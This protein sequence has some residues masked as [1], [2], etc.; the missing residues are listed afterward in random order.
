M[1]HVGTVRIDDAFRIAGRAGRVAHAA[2]GVFLE[3]RPGEIAI[4][5]GD[6]VLI[7][8]RVAQARLWHVR[9][10]GQDDVALDG[11]EL[12]LQLL[13]E[14]HESRV[15]KHQPV[16]GVIGD[17]GDL[18]G[19]EAWI[20]GVIDRPDAGDAV[21]CF[22]MPPG[23]PGERRDAVTELDAF[24]VEP[25]RD[26][27]CAGTDVAVVGAVDRALD[28]ARDHFAVAVL[29]R[30]VVGKF[31]FI[32][33]ALGRIFCRLRSPRQAPKVSP[34][35]RYC[36]ATRRVVRSRAAARPHGVPAARAESVR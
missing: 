20:D 14:R 2:G 4:D 13:H 1:Q 29:D 27:Q 15:E 7:G 9:G 33:K 17:V 8:H 16:F 34:S 26:F 30:G 5:L 32:L 25:L 12:V 10:V 18:F 19:K 11:R 24:L 36:K 3:R 31:Q 6:P 22:Q 35:T 28:G 23:V 21:P